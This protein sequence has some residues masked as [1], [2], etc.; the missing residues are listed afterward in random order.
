MTRGS[1]E[2]RL[3]PAPFRQLAGDTLP[4][5]RA[6]WVRAVDGVRLRLALWAGE[7]PRGTVLLFPGRTEYAEK[8]APVAARLVSAGLAVLAIDWRGQGASARLLDDPRPGHVGNFAEYQADVDALTQA[9]DGLG[10]PRPWHLLA[11]SMGGCIGLRALIRGG[12]PVATAAF[13][14]PMW[15]IRV[16]PLPPRVGNRLATGLATA[17]RRS[18]RS[19]RSTRGPSSV[20]DIAFSANLLTGNVD[21]YARFMRE[22]AAWPDLHLG[23]AT[24]GW[25]GAALAECRSLAALPSPALPA[26]ITVSG[27]EALVMPGAIR[28]RAADWPAATLL[29]L[30]QARH[31]ALFEL[32]EI[33]DPLLQAIIARMT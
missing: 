2:A 25:V 19:G 5:A 21:E 6:F 28:S 3:Q 15:G 33:R 32:P 1:E 13:S 8:Y 26:L 9:A 31:E 24:W 10:L 23:A 20:L 14:S 16:S 11:H 17:A 4:P 29:E 18:G 22:A 27:R 30:P 12:V 7:G